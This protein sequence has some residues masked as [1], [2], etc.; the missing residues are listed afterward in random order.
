MAITPKALTKSYNHEALMQV[1][2]MEQES[3][4]ATSKAPSATLLAAGALCAYLSIMRDISEAHAGLLDACVSWTR[5]ANQLMEN[6]RLSFGHVQIVSVLFLDL[7]AFK[8]DTFVARPRSAGNSLPVLSRSVRANSDAALRWDSDSIAQVLAAWRDIWSMLSAE[9]AERW[10]SQ[11]R[12]VVNDVHYSTEGTTGV[13]C[14]AQQARAMSAVMRWMCETAADALTAHVRKLD[15]GDAAPL[16]SFD[17]VSERWKEHRPRFMREQ[18]ELHM[19]HTI[20]SLTGTPGGAP[21]GA[22]PAPK[23]LT[24]SPK[25][26]SP[27]GKAPRHWALSPAQELLKPT[28]KMSALAREAGFTGADAWKKA[29]VAFDKQQGNVYSTT[30]KHYRRCAFEYA[31]PGK[32]SCRSPMCARCRAKKDFDAGVPLPPGM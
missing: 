24:P 20:R 6:R 3:K 9:I 5:K 27:D 30:N 12:A 1:A 13:A 22:R 14:N 19:A 17:F 31:F 18:Y 28:P 10:F 7:N 16:D 25:P 11:A 2:R 23:P 29:V 8:L 21:G 4:N 15:P 26:S 32:A